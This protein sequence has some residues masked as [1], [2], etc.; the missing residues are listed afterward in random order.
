MPAI[1]GISQTAKAFS[2]DYA[3]KNAECAENFKEIIPRSPRF[4]LRN[5]R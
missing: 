4:S 3:E 5:P 2:A 1:S